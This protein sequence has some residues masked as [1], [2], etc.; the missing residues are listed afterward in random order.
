MQCGKLQ[1]KSTLYGEQ[2]SHQPP[3]IAV[4]EGAIT[5][6]GGGG[7]SSEFMSNIGLHGIYLG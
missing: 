2:R 6:P 5:R 1:R 3:I 7:P 4:V